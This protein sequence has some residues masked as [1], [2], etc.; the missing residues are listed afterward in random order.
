MSIEKK[1]R[2]LGVLGALCVPALVTAAFNLPFTF[3]AGSPIKADEVNAN[4]EALRARFNGQFLRAEVGTLTLPGVL[5]ASPIRS[6]TQS[7]DVPVLVV[8]AGVGNAKP[9]F[10]DIEIS[11]DAGAGT[12]SLNLLVNQQKLL[13]TADIVMGNLSVHLTDVIVS[14]VSV[15]GVQVGHAQE[16]VRLAF[17]TVQWSWQEGKAPA[18]VASW[19]RVKSVG[20]GAGPLPPA[21][22]YFAPGVAPTADYV[23]I[24]GY[25]HRLSCAVSP[26]K[27]AQGAVTVQKAVGPETIDLLGTAAIAK[28]T[29]AVGLTWFTSATAAS[30]SLALTDVLVSNVI[31]TTGEDGTVNEMDDFAYST[32]TWTAGKVQTG[33]DAIK[34]AAL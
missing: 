14:G 13:P 27:V 21:F 20:A 4:F 26:C 31:L 6:F 22:A 5:A 12:P 16:T 1:W 17:S 9:V 2:V 32:I 11:R 19:D 29:P 30:H 33:W 24:T 7:I 28:H 15:N 34:G 18:K 3:K 8:G 10:S 23:P 25:S